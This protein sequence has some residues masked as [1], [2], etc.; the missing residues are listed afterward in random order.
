MARRRRRPGAAYTPLVRAVSVF[1]ALGVMLVTSSARTAM[2]AKTNLQDGMKWE[3]LYTTIGRRDRQLLSYD[4][5]SD[6]SNG[7][8]DSS[9]SNC[10]SPRDT[11]VGYNNSCDYILSDCGD[12]AQLFDYLKLVLCNLSSVQVPTPVI[13][14]ILL[15]S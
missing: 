6:S 1:L 5:E 10:L 13:T 12:I 8:G 3:G 7:S 14:Y 4:Y 2:K 9:S 15:L 11:H